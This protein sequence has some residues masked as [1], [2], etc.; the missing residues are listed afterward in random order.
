MKQ[1]IT[2][3]KYPSVSGKA[4]Y[5]LNGTDRAGRKYCVT[6]RLSTGEFVADGAG[7]F[8]GYCKTRKIAMSA[9]ETKS[10]TTRKNDEK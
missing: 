8:L 9:C 2:R 4:S 3:T 7:A 10:R 1:N 6:T 5:F